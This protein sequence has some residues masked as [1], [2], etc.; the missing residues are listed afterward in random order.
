LDVDFFKRVNDSFGHLAGDEVLRVLGRTL[1]GGLRA[2]DVCARY[3]GEE[4]VVIL[5][6][7]DAAGALTVA[8]RLRC[9]I[10]DTTITTGGRELRV[11][12][13]IGVGCTPNGSGTASALIALAD[14]ALYDAKRSG[15]NRVVLGEPQVGSPRVAV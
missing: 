11:T 4:L 8:E 1:G 10:A 6:N 13:S 14:A 9:L 7:T 15:R 12:V 5:P 2:G 3:G